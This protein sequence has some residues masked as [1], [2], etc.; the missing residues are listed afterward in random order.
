MK[1]ETIQRTREYFRDNALACIAE[2]ESG[3]VILPSH[4]SLESYAAWRRAEAEEA[5][6]GDW[7]NS[8]T[9]RQMAEYLETGVCRA[10]LP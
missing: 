10:L 4:T 2:V 8:F 1:P 9:F 3:A 7:D 5:M 6:R